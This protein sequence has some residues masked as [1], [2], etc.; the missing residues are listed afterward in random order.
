MSVCLKHN[1][2]PYWYCR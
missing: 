1:N 2:R